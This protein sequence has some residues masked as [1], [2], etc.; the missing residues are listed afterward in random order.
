MSHANNKINLIKNYC[1]MHIIFY[2]KVNKF[3]ILFFYFCNLDTIKS[4]IICYI[5]R[6]V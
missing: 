5:M 6:L 4:V 2:I 1:Y 3:N